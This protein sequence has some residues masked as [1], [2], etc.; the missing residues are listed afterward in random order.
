M[1]ILLC[2]GVRTRRCGREGDEEDE[3]EE[4]EG[5]SYLSTTPLSHRQT[6]SSLSLY[7]RPF[8]R[9]PTSKTI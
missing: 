9:R 7:V 5:S 4:G 2:V 1:P 6:S 3:E 8:S